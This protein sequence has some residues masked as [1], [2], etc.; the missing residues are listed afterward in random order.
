MRHQ[1]RGRKLSRTSSHRLATMRSLSAAL[2]KHHRIV[3]TVAKAKELRRFVEP[4][5]SRAT[6]DDTPHNRRQIF[7]FLNDKHA[8]TALY[9]EVVPVVGDR[10]GGYTRVIKIGNRSGDGAPT[11]LIE[12]VDFND[13]KPEGKTVKKKRTRRAGKKKSASDTDSTSEAPE[14]KGKEE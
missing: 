10:P 13:V 8:V 5:I 14:E 1:V 9:D 11:A 4:V 12:L 3:T 6:K 2:I 7:S